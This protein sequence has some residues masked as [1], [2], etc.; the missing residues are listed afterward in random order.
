MSSH[1]GIAA[2]AAVVVDAHARMDLRNS[3]SPC[4]RDDLL[5]TEMCT[6]RSVSAQDVQKRKFELALWLNSLVA[7][8]PMLLL[9]LLLLASGARTGRVHR[10]YCSR[11]RRV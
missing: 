6:E 10:G 3:A 5:P 1:R 7:S 4:Q 2:A 8:V 9:L 11:R